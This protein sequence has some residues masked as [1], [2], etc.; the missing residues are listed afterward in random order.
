MELVYMKPIKRDDPKPSEDNAENRRKK[1]QTEIMDLGRSVLE[2][3]IS[4][5]L[6]RLKE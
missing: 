6:T 4:S 3:K 1:E 5:G 2:Q